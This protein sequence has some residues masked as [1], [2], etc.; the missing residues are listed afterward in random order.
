[1]PTLRDLLNSPTLSA[2][3][4]SYLGAM[5]V[6]AAVAGDHRQAAGALAQLCGGD[7][8]RLPRSSSWLVA[9]YGVVEAAHLLDDA[10]T[11]SAAYDLIAPYAALPMVASLGVACFGSVQ[12][13]LGVACLTMGDPGRAVGHLRAA[14]GDNLALGHWPAAVTSRARLAQALTRRNGPGDVATAQREHEVAVRDAAGLGMTLPA[15]RLHQA[16]GPG[17]ADPATCRRRGRQWE[18]NLGH[19]TVL[20]EHSRGMQYLATLIAN[21]AQEIRPSNWPPVQGCPIPRSPRVPRAPTNPSWTTWP[22]VTTAGG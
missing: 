15:D 21:P 7:L 11:S 14:V 18:I 4:N 8:G 10:Q 6:A 3:D 20:V 12:Q 1:V 22:N 17:A 19:R 13:A 2:V 16:V 5:A 9:M